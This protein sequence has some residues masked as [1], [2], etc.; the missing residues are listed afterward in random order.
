MDGER[1]SKEVTG[2]QTRRREKKWKT[3]I[4]VDDVELNLR[5]MGVKRWR[6]RSLE[7]TE[8]TSVVRDTKTKRK[9]LQC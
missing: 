5:N 6:T 9:G 8:E 4:K 7:G 2:S 1:T 3:Q